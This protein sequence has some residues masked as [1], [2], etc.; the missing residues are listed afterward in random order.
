MIL[1]PPY[2]D[3]WMKNK[4]KDE[5]I[6][7][8]KKRFFFYIAINHFP[9]HYRNSNWVSVDT[10]LSPQVGCDNHV[11]PGIWAYQNKCTQATA[12]SLA[13]VYFI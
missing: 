10:P 6:K 4:D 7:L 1:N 9:F 3:E 11:L 2:K 13:Y 8:L 12:W 5:W